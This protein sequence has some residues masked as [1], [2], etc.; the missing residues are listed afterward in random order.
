M[1]KSTPA[2]IPCPPRKLT[3][4]IP[5]ASLT[6][7]DENTVLSH[8]NGAVDDEA[9]TKSS[10]TNGTSGVR[11]TLDVPPT[12][13]GTMKLKLGPTRGVPPHISPT[14]MEPA[15]SGIIEI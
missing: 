3:S 9:K 14:P 15:F 11:Q 5:P 7:Q 8:V 10:E 1:L 13:S 4:A 6:E 2:G 12:G